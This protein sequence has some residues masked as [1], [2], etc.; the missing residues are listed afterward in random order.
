MQNYLGTLAS[1][2]L[3]GAKEKIGGVWAG[4]VPYLPEAEESGF[5]KH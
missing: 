4:V 1:L 5:R 2:L 3:V